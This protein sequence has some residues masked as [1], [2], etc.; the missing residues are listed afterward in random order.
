MPYPNGGICCACF[1]W[2]LQ[3]SL[4]LHKPSGLPW[5]TSVDV[6]IPL[7]DTKP[8]PSELS[9]R[10]KLPII[11]AFCCHKKINAQSSRGCACNAVRSTAEGRQR[12]GCCTQVGH[13]V[14]GFH[15]GANGTCECSPS[16]ST[17]EGLGSFPWTVHETF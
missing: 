1:E 9:R 17:P 10:V 8:S 16:S 5:V 6:D 3:P 14:W 4:D 11:A 13:V 7:T 15:S 12:E 2:H